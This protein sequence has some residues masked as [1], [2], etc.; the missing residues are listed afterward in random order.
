MGTEVDFIKK[1]TPAPAPTTNVW[2]ANRLGS[3]IKAMVQDGTGAEKGTGDLRDARSRQ[4]KENNKHGHGCEWDG[5]D[6]SSEKP[7]KLEKMGK[8]AVKSKNT[9]TGG[10]ELVSVGQNATIKKP[11]FRNETWSRKNSTSTIK[12]RT[13][14]K[15]GSLKLRDPAAY[16]NLSTSDDLFGGTAMYQ[17]PYGTYGAYGGHRDFMP[18]SPIVPMSHYPMINGPIVAPNT[19]RFPRYHP[20]TINSIILQPVNPYYHPIPPS[21]PLD[22]YQFNPY[23]HQ[24]H[25]Q[26]D[27]MTQNHVS[28]IINE[29]RNQVLY[30]FSPENLRKDEYLKSLFDRKSGGVP[31]VELIKFKRLSTM[32]SNGNDL[33]LLQEVIRNEC[34]PALELLYGAQGISVKLESWR[35]WI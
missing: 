11:N 15:H 19:S 13:K 3:K 26:M 34:F 23:Y 4:G 24:V 25:P 20:D 14:R 9:D 5:I 8:A 28:Y 29:I 17:A 10:N 7:G 30:Y 22:L 6:V 31:L 1:L 27:P 12:P 2:T 33:K 21:P 35:N 16:R 18:P 32:T